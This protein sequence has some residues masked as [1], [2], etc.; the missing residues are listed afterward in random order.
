MDETL[1]LECL[2]TYP[3]ASYEGFPTHREI[4]V[5]ARMLR[6]SA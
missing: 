3:H 5:I 6:P 2:R 1:L 4:N